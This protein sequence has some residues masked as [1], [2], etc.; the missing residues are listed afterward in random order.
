M[1]RTIVM[2]AFVIFVF[3]NASFCQKDRAMRVMEGF[4][5]IIYASNR[6][7]YYTYRTSETGK[8]SLSYFENASD[9]SERVE[10]ETPAVPKEFKGNA[11]TFV[12]ACGFG[13][14]KSGQEHSFFINS[15]KIS[16]LVIGNSS[17]TVSFESGGVKASFMLL[18]SDRRR[19]S[20]GLLY[21]TVAPKIISYGKPVKFKVTGPKYEGQTGRSRYNRRSWFAVSCLKGN[22]EF[23]K[24]KCDNIVH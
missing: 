8:E 5:K 7:F 21:I 12:I 10:W 24:N 17:G 2:A 1:Y 22:I 3:T 18:A 16:G 13:E 9:G 4:G 15:R 14:N 20:Y 23:L 6:D 11:V 19:D